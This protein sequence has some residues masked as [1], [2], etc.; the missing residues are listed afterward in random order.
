M[1]RTSVTLTHSA[2]VAELVLHSGSPGNAI[3]L[4]AYRE[5]CEALR[6]AA[7]H[8][9]VEA[10]LIRS[11]GEDF[12]IGEDWAELSSLEKE[13]R[14]SDWERGYRGWVPD[15]WHN[16]KFV[17]A[18]V[19]GRALGI[20]CELALMADVT[21]AAHGAC[22]GHPETR[23][24]AVGHTLWPWL[25][26]P[27]VAKEYLAT[28]ALMS[29]EIAQRKGLIN[30]ALPE[31]RLDEH[32]RAFVRDLAAMPSG[33]PGANKRRIN[34]AFRDVSR[35]LH[36]DRQY[37]VDVQ[38]VAAARKVDA[39][40]YESVGRQGVAKAVRARDA[41]FSDGRDPV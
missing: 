10:I 19:R 26:G 12:S 3:H 40:F 31:E 22:F 1:S 36:D 11:E 32:A 39:A 20:G 17:V 15:T 16:P 27:K 30:A 5:I 4:Q 2:K 29:A 9:E 13:G 35:V 6:D 8:P 24:G 7:E 28:G 38:W 23:I 34:W 37:D 21:F 18:A 14:F 25:V 33:T 41:H